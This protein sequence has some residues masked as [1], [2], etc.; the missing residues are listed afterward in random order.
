MSGLTE[1]HNF[2]LPVF[3]DVTYDFRDVIVRPASPTSLTMNVTL[4]DM[5]TN[6][7]ICNLTSSLVT[8]F[9]LFSENE[10]CEVRPGIS[11][12]ILYSIHIS[13]SLSLSLLTSVLKTKHVF[14]SCY[15][16][17]ISKHVSPLSTLGS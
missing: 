6:A 11:P 9:H 10:E 15:I 4:C 3:N 13:L 8:D 2:P 12:A 14:Q 5:E 1:A 7:F 16:V 17:W